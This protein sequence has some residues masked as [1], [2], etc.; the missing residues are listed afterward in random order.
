MWG[1]RVTVACYR[2]FGRFLS[3]PLILAVVG[4]FFA[5]DRGGRAASRAYLER[6]H[7]RIAE[8]TWSPGPWQSFLHF[9]EFGLSIADRIS[10]WG[11]DQ[12]RFEFVFHGRE[13]FKKLSEQ[14]KGAIL[15]GAHLGSFDALRVLS[16]QDRVTVNV[17]MYT[18]HAPK[19][20]EVFRKISPDV[21]VRVIS[22]DPDS[23][24]TTFEIK[25]CIDRG[26]WVAILGDRVEPSD[27]NRVCEAEFL[28]ETATF[29]EAPFLLPVI[30]G[31]PALMILALRRGGGVYEVFAEPLGEG[32]AG[33]APAEER[34]RRAQELAASY[35]ARLEHYCCVAPR[36]WF[37]FYDFWARN[38]S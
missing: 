27:R 35:A 26:E 24:R 15:F 29:P 5:T 1:L 19:I 37:N 11:G 16:V 4:Y 22:A 36:Q 8:P 10:L 32:E 18:R 31:C 9:C 17:L 6:V 2:A 28:G 12:D 21:D 23:A 30:L 25:A 3:R 38:P 20:N 14:G 34:G 7:A 33:R 13:H